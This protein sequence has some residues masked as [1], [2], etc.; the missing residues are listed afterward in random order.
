MPWTEWKWP[1][2][3]KTRILVHRLWHMGLCCSKGNTHLFWD[4]IWRKNMDTYASPMEYVHKV[5]KFESH[6]TCSC[7]SYW[8]MSTSMWYHSYNIMSKPPSYPSV[9]ST[10]S[11]LYLYWFNIMS[12]QEDLWW[13]GQGMWIEWMKKTT[14]QGSHTSISICTRRR[15]KRKAILETPTS[16]RT[17]RKQR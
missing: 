13:S 10:L 16:P 4:L 9:W 6:S 14:Y 7:I 12:L 5:V 15:D 1:S 11:F 8:P 2:I 3:I 17:T